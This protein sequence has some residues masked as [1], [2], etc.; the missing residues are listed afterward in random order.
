MLHEEDLVKGM[1]FEHELLDFRVQPT[2]APIWELLA[3]DHLVFVLTHL[4]S[5]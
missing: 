2:G 4:R 3:D 1:K 5:E